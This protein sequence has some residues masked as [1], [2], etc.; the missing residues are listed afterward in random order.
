MYMIND[1]F[2]QWHVMQFKMNRQ[3]LCTIKIA[4]K[5]LN[6]DDDDDLSFIKYISKLSTYIYIYTYV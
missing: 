2:L 3:S 6:D 1:N 4:A 5:S